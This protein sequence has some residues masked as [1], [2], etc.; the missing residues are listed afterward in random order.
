MPSNQHIDRSK[1]SPKEFNSHLGFRALSA[2]RTCMIWL[3]LVTAA[4]FFLRISYRLLQPC[5]SIHN[6]SRPIH[7]YVESAIHVALD[8]TSQRR[9]FALDLDGAIIIPALTSPS[10]SVGPAIQSIP[11]NVLRGDLD[12]GCWSFAGNQ[13][14]IGIRLSQK[15]NPTHVAVDMLTSYAFDPRAP[16]D[17]IVWGI[18]DGS[19]S[20]LIFDADLRQYRE[21]VAH[22]GVG[23]AQTLGYDFLP[24][25]FFQY[26]TTAAFPLQ[27]FHI[28]S[29]VIA[30]SMMFGVVVIEFRNNWGGDATRVCRLRV[31]GGPRAA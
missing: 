14:Q 6:V 25:A 29:P 19:A 9:N 10:S 17:T 18:V 2:L 24:L 3:V 23:P 5:L 28:A 12:G 27:V 16:R 11:G 8:S 13:G 30:S 22:Y 7:E 20:R 26:N 4:I 1:S 21:T 31:H 15:I